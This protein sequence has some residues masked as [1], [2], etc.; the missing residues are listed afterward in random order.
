[1]SFTVIDMTMNLANRTAVHHIGQ[2]IYEIA[3]EQCEVRYWRFFLP[4]PI[5]F[6]AHSAISNVG[7]LLGR[8]AF[9]DLDSTLMPAWPRRRNRSMLFLEPLFAKKTDVHRDD[10]VLCHDIAPITHPEFYG[11]L[12]GPSYAKAYMRIQ[13]AAPT[14]VFVSEFTKGQFLAR[15]PAD[16]LRCLVIP[17]YFKTSLSGRGSLRPNT[18]PFILMVGTLERR[19]NYKMALE[20]FAR[21]GLSDQGYDLII[22]G[23]RGN[24]SHELLPSISESDHVKHFGF[25]GDAQLKDLY[26]TA[27][28]LFFPSL[29]EGFGV[30]ALEAPQS[31]LL[32]IVSE[33]TVL[34]EIVG[35]D[36]IFVD[37]LSVGSMA[38][39]LQRAASMSEAERSA[40]LAQ[41][42]DYQG[43]YS[44]E[45]FRTAWSQVLLQPTI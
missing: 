35:P 20:A 33:G 17:L 9:R 4:R 2:E 25:V 36:G 15:F 13:R 6:T 37:P 26:A 11:A 8:L 32:P 1:M 7:K 38:Q 10:I 14:M 28:A 31:E 12:A 43:R 18:K 5:D 27:T 22:V 19:K 23:P 39:G 45:N 24:L 42:K 30:P 16:Y 29:V 44:L 34:E 3:R 21:S 41:I 40:R